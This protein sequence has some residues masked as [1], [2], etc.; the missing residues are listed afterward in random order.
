MTRTIKNAI[1]IGAGVVGAA[2]AYA[3]AKR[4]IAVT[5]IDARAEPAHGTSYANGGQLSYLYTE[6]LASHRIIRDLP[7]LALGQNPAF[8]IK[9]KPDPDYIIWLLGFLRNCTASRFAGNTRAALEIALKSRLAMLELMER[10]TLDFDYSERGKLQLLYDDASVK[11]ARENMVMKG[12]SD[13]DQQLL[14]ADDT[15]QKEHALARSGHAFK[16]SLFSP[17]EAVGDARKF[18]A[19]LLEL[20]VN[21][22]GAKTLLGQRVTSVT[23]KPEGRGRVQTEEGVTLDTDLVVL[24]TGSDSLLRKTLKI[25][26]PVAAMKGYSITAPPGV[27]APEI[28]ITD[29]RRRIVFSRLGNRIRIAGMADLGWNNW[30]I[31][32]KRM[33]VLIA[34]AKASLPFAAEYENAF[35]HW[36]GLRPMT[37]DSLPRVGQTPAGIGYNLGHGMLGWTMAMGTGEQLAERVLS[38]PVR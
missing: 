4:G 21:Q 25:D 2:T 19:A 30:E 36:T 17:A 22:L 23:P 15:I 12:M 37:P 28:S 8:R 33:D 20:C 35:D 29:T 16:A 24:C 27:A 7:G 11:A 3:L 31:D 32:P 18:A 10:H 6:A 13:T 1:I 9:V 26:V 34:S 38:Q 5:I 14:S